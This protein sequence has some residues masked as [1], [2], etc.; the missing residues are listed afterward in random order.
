LATNNDH[1]GDGAGGEDQI[2]DDDAGVD[3]SSV[4]DPSNSTTG[5]GDTDGSSEATDPAEGLP[6]DL[7]VGGDDV[8]IVVEDPDAD[9]VDV[10]DIKTP[11]PVTRTIGARTLAYDT[12]P[13]KVTL[14]N[15]PGRTQ[16]T[17][18]PDDADAGDCEHGTTVT[19]LQFTSTAARR[20]R[21]ADAVDYDDDD[22]VSLY[23]P[24]Y[25][26]MRDDG[27]THCG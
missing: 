11:R 24:D 13:K 10:E 4:F 25:V 6:D 14:K 3:L 27:A 7:D 16:C 19:D 17:Q 8:G 22:L 9:R 15:L 18:C 1:D 2:A 12:Y 21:V 5:S 26:P 23:G 20:R